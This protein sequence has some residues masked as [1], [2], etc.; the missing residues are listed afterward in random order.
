MKAI[1][2]TQSGSLQRTLL[3]RALAGL[4]GAIAALAALPQTANAGV[5]IGVGVSVGIPPPPLPIYEQPPI[6]G[7]GYIW[8]PGY[9]AW[10]GAQY[11]WVPGTWVLAPFYGALW[12][13]GYW[14]W[15]GGF[16]VFHPGYW[17]HHVGFYGG[18]NY[19]CGY[20]GVGYVGGYWGHGGFYYNR[21]VNRFG[22]AHITN[23]YNRTVINNINVNRVS[24]N[25][26][27]G[28][29][30]AHA[31]PQQMSYARQARMGPIAA[32]KQQM[33]LASRNP[34]LRASFNHGNPPI[35]AT[36]R[37]GA[38]TAG[39]VPARGAAP[40]IPS[41]RERAANMHDP[42]ITQ[43]NQGMALHSANFAPHAAPGRATFPNANPT[44]NA[45]RFGAANLPR[46]NGVVHA[47]QTMQ[48]NNGMTLR[49]ANFAPHANAPN[50]TRPGGNY[51]N[52][53][54]PDGVAGVAP[55]YRP[56]QPTR[57]NTFQAPQQTVYRAAPAF[58]SASAPAYR[59]QP[60]FRPQPQYRAPA[61]QYR[62]YR[63]A[64]APHPVSAAPRSVGGHDEHHR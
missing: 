22:G 57:M 50:V 62:A 8:T 28:G 42:R 59:P 51:S 11:Y 55:T 60:Q 47:P 58:H 23:V 32:Q 54:R 46:A 6:P 18:I 35:A 56:T 45:G 38:F 13:P 36:Q 17:G 61:P 44:A 7:P 14:G 15:D 25:G 12:T 27:R 20:T 49:S 19:G 52:L 30:M 63:P 48:P 16:Y 4:L 43:P 41:M 26:G 9:W 37:P 1:S 33:D 2:L 34:A 53:H 40:S 5:F 31:T 29:I 21:A 3:V 24:Y 64:S 39:A 10:D